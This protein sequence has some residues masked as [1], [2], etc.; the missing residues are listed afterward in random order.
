[1]QKA[2]DTILQ[3]EVSADLAAQNGSFEPYRYECAC[4]GEEVYIAAAQST[5]MVPHFRHRNGNNDVK[6]ENYL[7]QYGTI[8]IDSRSR[9]SNCER[10]EF[11]F[12]NSTKTFS[13][14]LRFSDE[15]I[16]AYEEH[17]AIFELRLSSVTQAFFTLPINNMNF[18]PETTTLIPISQF[19]FSYFLSNTLNG[20]KRKYDLFKSD[21]IPIFFKLQGNDSNHRAKLVRSTVLYTNVS[22]FAVFQSQY[23]LSREICFFNNSYD[24]YEEDTFTFETMGK[25]FFGELFSIK[26]KSTQLENLLLSWGYQLEASETLTLLWPPATLVNDASVI[27]SDWAFLYSSFELQAHGNINVHSDNIYKTLD[28]VSRVLIKPNTKI[29]K[30][31]TE[32][33]IDCDR[34][35]NDNYDDL[36]STVSNVETYTVLDDSTYFLFSSSGVKP[37]RKGQSVLLTQHDEIRCYQNGYLIGRIYALQ[38]KKLSGDFLL[39]DILLHYKY[40]E[41][42]D[43]SIFDLHKLSITAFQYIEKCKVSGLINIAAK[44]FMEEGWL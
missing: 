41:T 34:Q 44:R 19:S 5:S 37:L 9:K 16:N 42:F 35:H 38:Q 22:Y 23:S 36:P 18:A 39:N 6:C 10:V 11:Y 29:A 43:E 32:I 28:R 26:S 33:T 13:I 12:E 21:N 27:D 24:I 4:C 7:G 40:V 2:Y 30:K 31:N 17:N 3:S 15:E 20:T 8:S 14:G 1:M 25:K